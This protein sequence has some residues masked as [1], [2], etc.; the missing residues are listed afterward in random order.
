[1][2]TIMPDNNSVTQTNNSTVIHSICLYIYQTILEIQEQQPQLLKEKYRNVLWQAPRHQATVLRKLKEGLNQTKNQQVLLRN[3]QK[4]LQVLLTPDYFQSPNFS[5]LMAKIRASTQYLVAD[6]NAAT[7]TKKRQHTEDNSANQLPQ[8]RQNIFTG[9][10]G[11]NGDYFKPSL[12][13]LPRESLDHTLKKDEG[14]AILLLDAENLQLDAETE[15]FLAEV[16]SYPLQ[17]KIAF[18]N[19]RT[20][21]KQDVELHRRSYE[22][23]HVPAGKDSADVKMATVGS[24]IFV[25]YPTAREVF[26]CSSDK[27]LT[28]LCNTL[29]T[30]GLTVYSVYRQGHKLRVFNNQDGDLKTHS[31][32]P[33]AKI[34]SREEFIAQ[35][36]EIITNEQKNHQNYWI[37]LLKLSQLYKNKYNLTIT[38][39]VAVYLPGKRA[40]DIF[41]EYPAQFVTHQ[42]PEQSEI[43]ITI[44]NQ[45]PLAEAATNPSA[46]PTEVRV[47]DTTLSKINS[48]ADLEQSI[49]KIVQ[50]L[51]AQS[52]R[53]YIDISRVATEFNR[54]HGQTMKE[55]I[56][57]LQL[58][59]KYVTL[60]HSCSALKV[61]QR[62][63]VYTVALKN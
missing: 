6:S 45:L 8:A 27:V 61:Q 9:H 4:F 40:R 12:T 33:Q 16:C 5:N 24:S 46:Y 39:V 63:K 44:F 51:T 49:V 43:Y 57:Q 14:I 50:S 30:H 13:T 7:S 60:L 2:I 11:N 37:T 25:H 48:K 1:M 36:Q 17:I 59:V 26:V 47:Q 15:K 23:I 34:P 22:L 54:Q 62:G 19:W 53:S 35:L 32:T 10:E 21:G 56:T 29:Q 55:T 28:H 52:S 42:P 3:V 58:K 38:Q 31:L 41:L 18:A 20:M